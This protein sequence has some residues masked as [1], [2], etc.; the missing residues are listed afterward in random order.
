MRDKQFAGKGKDRGHDDLSRIKGTITRE[1]AMIP[2][3]LK[4][5]GKRI[6]VVPIIELEIAAAVERVD[7][8]MG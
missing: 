4:V 8:L 5:M 1:L 7:L 3:W 6:R 2:D